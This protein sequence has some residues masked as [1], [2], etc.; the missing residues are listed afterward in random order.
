MYAVHA[1]VSYLSRTDTLED[2]MVENDTTTE[3]IAFAIGE[4]YA[5]A[6]GAMAII[7]SIGRETES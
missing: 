2:T 4:E 5:A 7:H 3:I 6:N 1:Y